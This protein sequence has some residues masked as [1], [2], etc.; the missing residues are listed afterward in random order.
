MLQ[1]DQPLPDVPLTGI[2]GREVRLPALAGPGLLALIFFRG[3][4]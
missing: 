4:W 1:P 2:D 3:A